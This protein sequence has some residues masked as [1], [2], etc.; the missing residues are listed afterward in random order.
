M[1]I[2]EGPESGAPP[3]NRPLLGW[4]LAVLLVVAQLVVFGMIS[5]QGDNAVERLADAADSRIWW[6]DFSW[7]GFIGF[8]IPFLGLVFIPGAFGSRIR[9][10]LPPM[11]RFKWLVLGAVA[12]LCVGFDIAQ[13]V[14]GG[15]GGYAT[16]DEA[17]FI[18]GGREANRR[19]WSDATHVFVACNMEGKNNNKPAFHYRVVFASGPAADLGDR[20]GSTT[21]AEASF[22]AWLRNVRPIDDALNDLPAARRADFFSGDKDAE[23]FTAYDAVI[24]ESSRRGFHRLFTHPGQ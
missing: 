15:K 17:V 7:F 14:T 5:N 23:C 2:V 3:K 13:F 19:P 24:P 22:A 11:P 16:D 10:A 1:S 9:Q 12:L 4:L 6:S 18:S 8:L 21:T 20:V